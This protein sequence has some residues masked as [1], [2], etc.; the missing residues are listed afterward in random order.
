MNAMAPTRPPDLHGCRVRLTSGP[1]AAAAAR[2]RLR[3][4]ICAWHALSTLRKGG[5]GDG[6]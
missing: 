4:A 5:T 2:S 3:A 1:A 6:T